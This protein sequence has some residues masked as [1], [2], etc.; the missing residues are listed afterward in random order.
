MTSAPEGSY[1]KRLFH[2]A[3]LLGKKIVEEAIE[4]KEVIME[5]E[6]AQR[7]RQAGRQRQKRRRGRKLTL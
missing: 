7:D 6:S 2:D 3:D 4:L 1:T 5:A